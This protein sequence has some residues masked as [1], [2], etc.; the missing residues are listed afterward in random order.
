MKKII[1]I[2][3][4]FIFCS[5]WASEDCKNEAQ[6][7]VEIR[8]D[9]KSFSELEADIT[10]RR[11]G[12]GAL[13]GA[14]YASEMSDIQMLRLRGQVIFLNSSGA[15]GEKLYKKI[16]DSCVA[17]EKAITDRVARQAAREAAKAAKDSK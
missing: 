15:K 7:A 9:Y 8:E 6:K 12:A 1:A 17:D 11:A 3:S 16:Y 5:A 10:L 2:L 13:T 4:L 14:I